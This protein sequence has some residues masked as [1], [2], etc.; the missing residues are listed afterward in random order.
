M[1]AEPKK[2]RGFGGTVLTLLLTALVV[3]GSFLAAALMEYT[4]PREFDETVELGDIREPVVYPAGDLKHSLYPWSNYD[5]TKCRALTSSEEELL[6]WFPEF[7]SQMMET[8]FFS[9]GLTSLFRAV[10][11]EE[12]TYFYQRSRYHRRRRQAVYAGLRGRAGLRAGVFYL[13]SGRG[14]PGRTV[15]ICVQEPG[16]FLCQLEDRQGTPR[17]YGSH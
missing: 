15:A 11:Q 3:G 7:L 13:P 17:H 1:R 16:K 12:T 4:I 10:T 9:A 5:E 14:D 8:D 2:G 6:Q